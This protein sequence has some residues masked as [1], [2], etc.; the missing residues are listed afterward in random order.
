MKN[1]LHKATDPKVQT[2]LHI[3]KSVRD[4]FK[5]SVGEHKQEM[6]EVVEQLMQHW[7]TEHKANPAAER[8]QL[9][10]AA[11]ILAE[12][13]SGQLRQNPGWAIDAL[14]QAGL[15]LPGAT[16]FDRRS[17]HFSIEKQ[18]LGLGF[19]RWLLRRIVHLLEENRRVFLICDS[20]TTIFWFL[21]AL[22]EAITEQF[23]KSDDA[24]TSAPKRRSPDVLRGLT[25]ITNNI[26]GAEAFVT[27]AARQDLACPSGPTR[28]CDLVESRLLAGIFLPE[29]VATTGDD[30][31]RDLE[32]LCKLAAPQ[33]VFIGVATGN[34]LSIQNWEGVALPHLLARGRGHG[35]F[36][37]KLLSV[38]HE[39]FVLA[40]L[41]KIFMQPVDKLNKLLDYSP[42]DP[43]PGKR[44]YEVVPM[45]KGAGKAL[46]LVSTL[47]EKRSVLLA[48]S[49]L[50]RAAIGPF[51]LAPLDRDYSLPIAQVKHLLFP[52]DRFSEESALAQI[53]IELPHP[54]TRTEPFKRE[55]FSISE[56]SSTSPLK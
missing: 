55:F 1:K 52:F 22:G 53:E 46:K 45:P 14:I 25:L 10:Q 20:G 7:L 40:P 39:T 28:I 30:T 16:V 35:P 23:P 36:K 41:G 47:R 19:A 15:G 29:Y 32:T 5:T 33:T 56:P 31:D 6:S 18:E 9:E 21:K 48:H 54:Q 26:P 13:V 50:V 27:Y 17:G 24:Q 34:W 8:V 42:N 44:S 11:T 2:T 37:K 49:A 38:C 3:F 12:A 43:D 4:E 51:T